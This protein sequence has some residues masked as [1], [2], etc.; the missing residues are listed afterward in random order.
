MTVRE[1]VSRVRGCNGQYSVVS[2][3]GSEYLVDTWLEACECRDF[4]YRNRR[5]KHIRR[6]A[7]AI[8]AEP[9]P[10]AFGPENVAGELGEHCS[11]E[12]RWSR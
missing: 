7:F 3:L 1:D 4:E 9:V 5:C 11:S 6:V 8:G 12:P 10:A 2:H